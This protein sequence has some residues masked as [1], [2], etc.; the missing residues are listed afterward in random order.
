MKALV[1]FLA[2]S[3]MFI[4]VV[5]LLREDDKRVESERAKCEERGGIYHTAREARPLCFDPKA[6]R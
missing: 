3:V 5:L 6:F 4:L 2:G 1:P